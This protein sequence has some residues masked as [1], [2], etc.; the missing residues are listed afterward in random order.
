MAGDIH[1]LQIRTDHRVREKIKK[2]AMTHH[3]STA[4]IVRT[5]LELGLRLLEKL[6]E[7]Q[8]EMVTEY[9]QL[10]KKESRLKSKKKK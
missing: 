6:L 5:S 3:R 1:H 7:A 9:I 2:L 8:S 4:D 10:L